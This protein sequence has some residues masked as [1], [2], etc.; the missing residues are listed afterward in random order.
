MRTPGHVSSLLA[1]SA[2][3]VL[4][5]STAA[6]AAPIT[7]DFYTTGSFSGCNAASVDT[8]FATCTMGTATLTYFFNGSAALP[9][10]EI[11]TDAVPTATVEY[12]SFQMSG[13]ATFS[14]FSGA[15]FSLNFFQTGPSAGSQVLLGA[16]SGTVQ[17]QSGQLLWGPVTPVSWNIGQVQWTI[18]LDPVTQTIRIDPPDAGGAPGQAAPMRGTATMVSTAVPEPATFALM[19]LGLGALGVGA[20]RRRRATIA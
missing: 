20:R 14:N 16:L 6:Q 7:V 2:L 18:A 5:S 10:S 1:S 3:L 13:G 4:V 11:L 15:S 8:S 12:G 9:D 19:T 17:A